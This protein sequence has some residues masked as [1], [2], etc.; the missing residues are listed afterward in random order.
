MARRPSA[1]TKPVLVCLCLFAGMAPAQSSF[2]S[3]SIAPEL[4]N[5]LA[6]ASDP[7][8]PFEGRMAGFRALLEQRPLDP[9]VNR[10]YLAHF[11]GY[12]L[13]PLYDR[14]LPRYEALYREGPDDPARRYLYAL[15]FGRRNPEASVAMIEGIPGPWPQLALAAARR[16]IKP[17]DTARVQAHLNR[18][19]EACP[20]TLDPGA[21]EAIAA[22]A[23][24]DLKAGTAARLRKQL[25]GRTDWL[26][27]RAWPVLWQIEFQ[28]TPASGHQA[29]RARIRGDLDRL[30]VLDADDVEAR[31]A[32]LAQGY[33][34][35]NDVAGRQQVQA[36]LM[37]AVPRSKAAADATIDLW[38]SRNPAPDRSA[39]SA[40]RDAYFRKRGRAARDWAERWP[41][42]GNAVTPLYAAFFLDEPAEEL[43]TMAA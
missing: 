10:Y 19:A 27:L 15:A 12:A 36:E 4:A 6:R 26:A 28:L 13:L 29:L 9:G 41:D 5:A 21:L 22:D 18:F 43:A 7:T 30:R 8:L 17:V 2:T 1:V 34:L 32:A 40:E 23:A 38:D 3:C 31:L 37:R 14:Q 39:P 25:Q 20:D 35:V 33:T 42:Y 24:D 11:G 16:R